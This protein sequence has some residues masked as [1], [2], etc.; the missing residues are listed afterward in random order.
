M[1]GPL[2]ATFPT[3]SMEGDTSCVDIGILQDLV[4]EG[5]HDFGVEVT[6]TTPSV[7]TVGMP[8]EETV[9]ILDDESTYVHRV[10]SLHKQMHVKVAMLNL[11]R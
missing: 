11:P 9:T 4:L 3:S 5:D 7:V 6:S 8:S 1:A 2:Q 10:H